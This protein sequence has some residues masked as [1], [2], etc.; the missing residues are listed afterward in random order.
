METPTHQLTVHL[1]GYPDVEVDGRSVRLPRRKAV[2]LLA[3]VGVRPAGVGREVLAALLWPDYDPEQAFAY[4]RQALWELNKA[5]GKGLISAEGDTVGLDPRADLWVDVVRFERAL[6][7]WKLQSARGA[8]DATRSLEEAASLYREDFLAGFT[9]RDSAPFDEWQ[10]AQAEALRRQLGEALAALAR[11]YADQGDPDMAIASV[12]RWLAIDPLDESAHRDAMRFYAWAGQR[13]AALR[14]YETCVSQLKKELGAAPEKA[15]VALYEEIRSG[16]IGHQ[17]GVALLAPH[18]L[19]ARS[20]PREGRSVHPKLCS[21]IAGPGHAFCGPRERAAGVGPHPGGPRLPPAHP[22]RP[23]R[24]RQDAPGRAIPRHAR[25]H[26]SRWGSR[27][28]SGRVP[29]CGADGGGHRPS[30]ATGL[31]PPIQR[32]A[33]P[34]SRVLRAERLSSRAHHASAAR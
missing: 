21:A 17:D 34:G 14:Q 4:L 3:Y 22:G 27:G 10:S 15:T 1:F 26:V 25:E 6:S 16:S 11:V 2:A 8:S 18:P 28:A 24:D 12:Q 32:I 23:R 5:L 30:G 20:E 13:R 31:S 19:F 29:F 9:L 7:L 33:R